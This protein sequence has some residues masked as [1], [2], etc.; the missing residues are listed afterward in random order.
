MAKVTV[1]EDLETKLKVKQKTG[2]GMQEYLTRIAYKANDISDDDWEDLENDTQLWVNASLEAIQTAKGSGQPAPKLKID[3]YYY[4]QPETSNDTTEEEEEDDMAKKSKA[5]AAAPKAAPKVAAKKN[6]STK[7]AA[8]ATGR[9][10]K[11]HP[12][13]KIV[14]VAKNP[15]REGSKSHTNFQRYQKGMTI[16]EAAKAGVPIDYLRWD[17]SHGHIGIKF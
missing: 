15:Y 9:P 1:L 12:D 14:T 10:A 16:A 7:A 8:S 11:Y 17:A 6:G 3:G 4:K 2:E 5:K 13:A